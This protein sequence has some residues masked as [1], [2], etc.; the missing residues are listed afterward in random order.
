MA[1]DLK[2]GVVVGAKALFGMGPEELRSVVEG[3][4]AAEVSGGAVGGGSV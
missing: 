3:S 2:M 1:M 4:R